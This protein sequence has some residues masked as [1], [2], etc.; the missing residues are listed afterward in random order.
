MNLIKWSQVTRVE[1]MPAVAR[2]LVPAVQSLLNDCCNE[3]NIDGDREIALALASGDILAVIDIK[4]QKMLCSFVFSSKEQFK[5]GMHQLR[6]SMY[7]LALSEKIE[8]VIG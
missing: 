1:V 6:N 2:A 5:Y 7:E 3:F 8:D 4:T